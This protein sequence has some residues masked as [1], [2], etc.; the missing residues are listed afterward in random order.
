MEHESGEDSKG[1][2]N[3]QGLASACVLC[4]WFSQ[5][6]KTVSVIQ[7]ANLVGNKLESP[8]GISAI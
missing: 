8:K 6:P 1:L 5:V 3:E 4:H 2:G 7:G